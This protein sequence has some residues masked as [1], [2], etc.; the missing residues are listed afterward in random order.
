MKKRFYFELFVG[1]L[2][3]AAVLVFG[4]VGFAI[5]ALFAAYPFIVK[6]KADER[7]YQLFYQTGNITVILTLLISV[8]IY[9]AS[10]FSVNGHRIGELWLFLVCFSFLTM[11]G[12][13]G[14][15]IFNR[16]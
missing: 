3:L 16:N 8:G 5:F 12:I 4:T 15:I 13:S 14:L 6:S 2:G 7:E 11:H 9:F 10:D 1:I